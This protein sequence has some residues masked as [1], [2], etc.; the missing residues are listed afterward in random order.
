MT[1]LYTVRKGDAFQEAENAIQKT[2]TNHQIPQSDGPYSIEVPISNEA[3]KLY[4]A[5]DTDIYVAVNGTCRLNSLVHFAFPC[6]V[7]CSAQTCLLHI[8]LPEVSFMGRLV[9][10]TN[11]THY[12]VY[13]HQRDEFLEEEEEEGNQSV[14]KFEVTRGEENIVLF[15]CQ[16]EDEEKLD[17][18]TYRYLWPGLDAFEGGDKDV[19]STSNSVELQ[20]SVRSWGPREYRVTCVDQ[21]TKYRLA[22]SLLTVFAFTEFLIQVQDLELAEAL[23]EYLTWVRIPYPK[24]TN[25]LLRIS[26]DA[27]FNVMCSIDNSNM[28]W[29]CEVHFEYARLQLMVLRDLA[30]EIIELPVREQYSEMKNR[31]KHSQIIKLLKSCLRTYITFDGAA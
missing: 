31:L 18:V 13:H 27:I 23:E 16:Y 3:S 26:D 20:W 5:V 28:S 22:Q 4:F 1:L 11:E 24:I 30:V 21:Y 7:N 14:I 6:P 8:R 17:L 29:L 10:K 9:V 15:T 2:F 12:D 25:S 19:H